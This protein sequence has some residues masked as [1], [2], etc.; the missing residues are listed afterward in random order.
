[1]GGITPTTVGQSFVTLANLGDPFPRLRDQRG[2]AK[3]ASQ[4]KHPAHGN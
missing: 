2:I 3:T 1:M 4:L